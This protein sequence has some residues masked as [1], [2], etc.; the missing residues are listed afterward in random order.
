MATTNVKQTGV[1]AVE[2]AADRA[3]EFNERIIN[4]A[5]RAGDASL[6]NYA[7]MLERIATAQEAAAQHGGEWLVALGQAQARFTREFAQGLPAAMRELIER[8]EDV[9]GKAHRQARQV[10]GVA[11]V[12]GEIAGAVGSE[13]DVP[14]ARYDDLTVAEIEK[15]LS[16]LSAA[17]VS[18]VDAYERKHKNRKTVLDQIEAQRSG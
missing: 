8:A 5:K 2:S 13:R 4:F 7:Q 9:A 1:S 11:E 16:D 14:I 17:D 18:K 12:E 3:R 10:P 6:D 15:R